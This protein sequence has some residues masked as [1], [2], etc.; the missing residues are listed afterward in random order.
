MGLKWESERPGAMS[1]TQPLHQSA[2]GNISPCLQVIVYADIS[3]QPCRM[4]LL[5]LVNLPIP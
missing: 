2:L 4:T 5:L 1:Y 3:V